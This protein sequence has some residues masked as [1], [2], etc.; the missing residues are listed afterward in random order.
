MDKLLH[1]L[2]G[3]AI[4]VNPLQKPEHA[5]MLAIA[6]G[7]AKEVYDNKHKSKHTPDL[8][9]AM[10]TTTGALMVFVYRVEF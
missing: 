4:A 10:A 1:L 8:I 9:D 7:I 5:L 2:V 6:A 3:M